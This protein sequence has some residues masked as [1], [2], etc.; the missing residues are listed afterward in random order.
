VYELSGKRAVGARAKYRTAAES[1]ANLTAFFKGTK[2][3]IDGA[4]GVKVFDVEGYEDAMELTWSTDAAGVAQKYANHPERMASL[5]E[6]YMNEHDNS[7][8]CAPKNAK[9]VGRLGGG[10]PPPVTVLSGATLSGYFLPDIFLWE[11]VCA[12]VNALKYAP[13]DCGAITRP[14]GYM[15]TWDGWVK[16]LE[17]LRQ[18][19]PGAFA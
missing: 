3:P 16:V 8:G 7:K 18:H 14:D 17:H 13:E 2:L 6:S 10:Q 15:M 11:G 9:H 12:S 19:I 5:D 1:E 4:E